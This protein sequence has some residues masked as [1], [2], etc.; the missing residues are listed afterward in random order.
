VPPTNPKGSHQRGT[1]ELLESIG[2][3]RESALPKIQKLTVGKSHNALVVY[4]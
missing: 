3:K 1:K 4:A 2:R